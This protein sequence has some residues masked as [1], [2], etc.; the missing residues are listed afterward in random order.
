[1]SDVMK[2]ML[3]LI[4]ALF[5][6]TGC[7]EKEAVESIKV[8]A[9]VSLEGALNDVIEEYQKEN[10]VNIDVVTGSTSELLSRIEKGAE[11]DIYIPSSKEQINT[12][13]DD[14][15]LE[16]ENVTPILKNSIVII[17]K[18]QSDI[19]VKSFDT[20]AEAESIAMAKESE[21]VGAFAREIFINLNVFKDILKMDINSC[22][23]SLDAVNSVADGKSDVGVCFETDA[24]A[25]ADK[26]QIIAAAP[27]DSLNSE[28]LYSVAL[29]NKEEGLEPS[30]N[31]VKFAEYLDTPEA[32]DIFDN[33]D[34]EIYIS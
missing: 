3:L 23:S 30:D 20:A 28:V 8:F 27:K 34:F 33:F 5:I 16:Q 7:G 14:K 10:F 32:A 9:D 21:P 22:E 15:L 11:C 12:L 29:L 1:M 17:K 31:A 19:T 4:M 18:L 2:K 6:M 13:I 24:I 26:V 25:N